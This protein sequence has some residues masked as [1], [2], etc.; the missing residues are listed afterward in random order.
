[1]K[2]ALLS[3]P[4]IAI[5]PKGYG[6]IELV[7]ANLAEGLVKRGH[8]VTVFATGDSKTP[9]KCA[10]YY[11]QALGNNLVLKQNLYNIL[12]HTDAF[13]QHATKE[14]YDILHNHVGQSAF[15]FFDFLKVPFV[16]TLHGAYYKNLH[17]TSGNLEQ[18]RLT[19]ERFKYHPFI[20][21]SD[22]QRISLPELNYVKT[23]YNGILPERFKCVMKPQ[24]Y[25]AWIG[26]VTPNKGLD[27]AIRIAQKAHVKLKISAFIDQGDEAYV[28]KTIRPLLTGPYVEFMGEITDF[29]AKTAFLGNAKAVLFPIQWHEPFGLV[30]IE[31]MASGTPVIA[32]NKGSVPEVIEQGKTGFI[33]ETEE[34]MLASL[35]QVDTIDREYCHRYATEHF[36]VDTM[37]DAYLEAYAQVISAH[38]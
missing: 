36:S 19:M 27:I 11:K 23:I 14:K 2:I 29:E 13:I 38:G 12:L 15:F 30:M 34:E 25:I 37:V 32:F 26:R 4:W 31:S 20:S 6:G 28:E 9:A 17:A 22:N 1:M 35:S 18:K 21:I 16:H 5:P 10:Y 3:T 24:D 33:V 8:D 7:V